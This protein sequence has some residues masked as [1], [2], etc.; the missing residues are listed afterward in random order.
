M[1]WH[2]YDRKNFVSFLLI[3]TWRHDIRHNDIQYNDT[4][5]N[6]TRHSEIQHNNMKMQNSLTNRANGFS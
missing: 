5:N 1:I 3:P 4:K 2:I 6:G